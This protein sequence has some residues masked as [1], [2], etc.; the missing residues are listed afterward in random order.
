M[1][2]EGMKQMEEKSYPEVDIKV[3]AFPN[4]VRDGHLGWS[5]GKSSR[6]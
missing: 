5:I 3:T 2:T 6:E 1:S 4:L